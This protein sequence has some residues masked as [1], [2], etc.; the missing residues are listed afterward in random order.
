MIR[1]VDATER[2]FQSAVVDYALWHGWHVLHIPDV[3][4]VRHYPVGFPDLLLIRRDKVLF[5]E[6]KTRTGRVSREQRGFI[7]RLQ[8]WKHDAKV[9]RPSDWSEI[10][11]TLQ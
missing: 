10:E 1:N 8:D 4:R 9:W 11:K 2:E 7:K 6:L 3:R 5:R